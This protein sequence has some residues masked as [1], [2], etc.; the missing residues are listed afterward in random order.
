MTTITL[1]PEI[2]APLNEAAREQGTTP[3]SLALETLRRQFPTTPPALAPNAPKNLYE[4]LG[5]FVGA[6]EGSGEAFSENCGERFADYLV[7]KHRKES[8][9]K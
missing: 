3:E 9:S 6:I 4:F 8:A 5:D 2:E 7:E 1:P